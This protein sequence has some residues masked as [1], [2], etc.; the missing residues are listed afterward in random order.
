MVAH[1]RFQALIGLA[2]LVTLANVPVL[3]SLPRQGSPRVFAP[4]WLILVFGL[5]WF[6][7]RIHWRRPQILGAASGLFAAA[8]VLSLALSVS[9]RLES[10]DFSERS[11]RLIAGRVSNGAEVAVCGVR[12]TVT[13]PAPRGAFAVHELV[14]DWAAARALTY[15]TGKRVNFHLAGELWNQPCPK[16][17]EVDVVIA[18]DDLLAGTHP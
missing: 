6:G 9:V 10:A 12:R 3:L 5:A 11:V 8:A 1:D 7:A 2:V 4:T 14:Y 18:F 17:S 15:Y 13:T 16:A